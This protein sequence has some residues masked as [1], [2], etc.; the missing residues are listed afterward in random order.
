MKKTTFSTFGKTNK[1]LT[2]FSVSFLFIIQEILNV[3]TVIIK[4]Q[5]IATLKDYYKLLVHHIILLQFQL[6]IYQSGI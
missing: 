1:L 2:S 3:T 4:I 6:Y 5:M